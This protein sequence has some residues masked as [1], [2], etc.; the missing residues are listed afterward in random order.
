MKQ[1]AFMAVMTAV[2]M[3]GSFRW[4]PFAG[5]WVYVFYDILRPQYI[6]KWSL[7]PDINWSLYVAL[8]A[9]VATP[10]VGPAANPQLNRGGRM[11]LVRLLFTHRAYYACM[12]WFTL[13]YFT[14]IRP[15]AGD[16]VME[17]YYKTLLMY[18]VGIAAIHT[19]R[20]VWALLGAFVVALVY[21]AYEINS[22]YFFQG[23]LGIAL[24]GHGGLD[25]NGAGMLLAMGV[26]LCAFAWEGYRGWYRWLFAVMIPVLL[27][28]VLLT[29]SRRASMAPRL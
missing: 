13:T 22:L 21:I 24:N 18:S 19:V 26:P 29:Y 28:A 20:Q 7:P 1:L 15:S 14:A 4:G 6:W 11:T 27:H 2:G 17:G 23:Y 16:F 10:L 12:G 9:L 3:I 8:A 25:N 5:L